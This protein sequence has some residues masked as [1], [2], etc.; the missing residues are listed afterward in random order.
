MAILVVSPLRRKI[1]QLPCQSVVTSVLSA[2]N[3]SL[4]MA[5]HPEGMKAAHALGP[6]PGERN[7]TKNPVL[8]ITLGLTEEE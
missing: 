1:F 4:W 7:E 2:T 5:D 8:A 3:P 6:S